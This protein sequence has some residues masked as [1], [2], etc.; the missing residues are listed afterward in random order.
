[1]YS[2][3]YEEIGELT[4]KIVK[5]VEKEGK[6]KERENMENSNKGSEGERE[7]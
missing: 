5:S 4:G 2:Q 6:K 3:R 7:K 1:M